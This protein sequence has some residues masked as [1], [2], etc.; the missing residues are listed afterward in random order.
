M[1]TLT[2]MATER[3]WSREL[4]WFINELATEVVKGVVICMF[5]AHVKTNILSV[6]TCEVNEMI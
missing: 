4:I 2:G 1:S 5:L 3:P 6:D